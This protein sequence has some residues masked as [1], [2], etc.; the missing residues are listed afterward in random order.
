MASPHGDDALFHDSD[1][2]HR[3]RSACADEAS[4]GGPPTGTAAETPAID[5]KPGD[6]S[7][8]ATGSELLDTIDRLKKQQRDMKAERKRIATELRNAEKRRARLRKKANQLSV[9]DLVDILKIR[10]C[11]RSSPSG[12]SGSTAVA[13][14]HAGVGEEA[15]CVQSATEESAKKDA[16]VVK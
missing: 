1:G 10:A 15:G 5:E 7:T 12:S 6:T 4:G 9:V 16:S 8:S 11:G 14:L 3:E 2:E 13:A